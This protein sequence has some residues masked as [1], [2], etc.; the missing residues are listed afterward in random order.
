MKKKKTGK[1]N[2]AKDIKQSREN[3]KNR[4]TLKAVNCGT[5]VFRVCN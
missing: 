4:E 2:N 3:T 1:L 5:F